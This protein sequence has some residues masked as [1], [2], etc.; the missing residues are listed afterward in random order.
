VSDV[1]WL[2][3]RATNVAVPAMT[4]PPPTTIFPVGHVAVAGFGVVLF[5]ADVVPATRT[6]PVAA[7]GP[8]GP[9]GP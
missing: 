4:P 5:E 1:A 3:L 8:T 2:W 6:Y 7:A 9:A